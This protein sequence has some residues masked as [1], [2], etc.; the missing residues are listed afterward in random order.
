M[1]A[2]LN[3]QPS[4]EELGRSLQATTF[5]V[6][7]LETTGTSPRDGSG[8][9]EFG[10]VKICGGEVLG[11]FQTFVNPRQ[12]IP[13]FITVLT[14]ITNAMVINAPFI[15][16]V[17]PAFIE[18]CGSK[19]ETVLVAHNAP[20]DVGFLKGAAQQLGYEW[21]GYAVI[22]TARIARLVLS[23]E[24]VRNCKLG[25][26]S[27]FFGTKVTPTHRALDDAQAT[28]EVLHG[29]F[30]RLGRLGVS[31][32][33]DLVSFVHRVTPEQRSKKHLAEGIPAA[34]GVYIF[35]DRAGEALYV[36]TSRN[37]KTRVRNYFGAGETRRRIRDMI[38]LAESID[39][40]V[41]ATVLEAEIRELRHISEK[42]PRFNRR[43]RMQEKAVWLTLTDENFPRLSVVRGGQSLRDARGWCGPFNGRL[44]AQLA[45]EAIH[46]VVPLRQ[47]TKKISTK[48]IANGTSCALYD[49][50]R[51]GAPCIGEET[52]SEYENHLTR[53]R[54]LMQ[55]SATG[56]HGH[57]TSKMLALAEVQRFE[58]ATEYRDRLSA[59]IKGSSRSQRIR[60]LT[61]IPFLISA[62]LLSEERGPAW[63]F[64]CIKYGRLAGSAISTDAVTM[65]DTINSLKLTAEVISNSE[66]VL[67]A[68]SYEEVEKLLNYLEA[69]GIRL[70]DMEGDW[71][72]P[73]AGSGK[74]FSQ[75][76]EQESK[77]NLF[78]QKE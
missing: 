48:S 9:T 11:T 39:I 6:V 61:R 72:S 3:F 59:F 32:F 40:I 54:E 49:M 2:I 76:V 34:A 18:F 53:A 66:Q 14:G 74:Y 45:I 42:Q 30:E 64:I 25:T 52:A 58:E 13:A 19:T 29:L 23:K 51:C 65:V 57:L 50:G 24:E 60:S 7:D 21:P 73:A 38:T 63:E 8:I 27:E 68:S 20:F 77:W 12:D 56:L 28:V 70:V 1:S 36:G 26:L 55:I 46:E 37:L 16:E 41:C 31:T 22:D 43:S 67:P 4:F 33:E 47:C 71:V 17:F 35:R 15:E 10:A 78:T 75:R 44:E 62:K 69:P 5:V